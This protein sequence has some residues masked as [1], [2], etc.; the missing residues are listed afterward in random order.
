MF[1]AFFI[2]CGQQEGINMDKK[3][4]KD[5]LAENEYER[6][7]GNNPSEVDDDFWI[8]ALHYGQGD[9]NLEKIKERANFINNN[10]SGKI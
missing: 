5:R 2:L 10:S 4:F 6:R 9:I 7:Y 1:C 8:D 3:V